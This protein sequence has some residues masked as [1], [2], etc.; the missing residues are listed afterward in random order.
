MALK[1]SMDILIR[2]M[3]NLDARIEADLQTYATLLSNVEVH[4]EKLKQR[5]EEKKIFERLLYRIGGERDFSKDSIH[6]QTM[7][8]RIM[9]EEREIA[10]NNGL[11][12]VQQEYYSALR[13][14]DYKTLW[15]QDGA[16]SAMA[17]T[18]FAF[19]QWDGTS[20]ELVQQLLGERNETSEEAVRYFLEK[21][22]VDSESKQEDDPVSEELDLFL[23]GLL[24]RTFR[25]QFDMVWQNIETCLRIRK[26]QRTLV[27]CEVILANYQ[28]YECTPSSRVRS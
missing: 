12:R 27:K 16:K 2:D 24:N 21:A 9:T 14:K 10:N 18:C 1:E 15:G 19:E 28:E 8:N 6:I 20:A 4:T 26:T 13:E 11:I 17:A 3:K 25:P 7:D 23:S 22:L 5:K